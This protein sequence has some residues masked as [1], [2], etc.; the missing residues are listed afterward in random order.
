VTKHAAA[1]NCNSAR[2]L[3]NILGSSISRPLVRQLAT[4]VEVAA[5]F[6]KLGAVSPSPVATSSSESIS[7]SA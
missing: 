2:V 4:L 6:G 3:K 1:S 5:L 7:V